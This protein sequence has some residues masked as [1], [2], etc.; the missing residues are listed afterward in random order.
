MIAETNPSPWSYIEADPANDMKQRWERWRLEQWVEDPE[1]RRIREL[2]SEYHRLTDEFDL[3]LC[4]E[5][6]GQPTSGA[7]FREMNRNARDVLKRLNE[8]A[9]W[10]G[11]PTDL[12]W[13]EIQQQAACSKDSGNS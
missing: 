1:A 11:L 4:P 7:Q 10:E 9:R 12:L 3:K 8:V 5:T 2:A 13:R 6:N